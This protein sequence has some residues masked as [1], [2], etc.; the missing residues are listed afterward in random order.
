MLS[1]CHSLTFYFENLTA[2][3]R[4]KRLVHILMFLSNF[5]VMR[6]IS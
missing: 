2:R 6:F 1:K 5:S 3:E 4:A